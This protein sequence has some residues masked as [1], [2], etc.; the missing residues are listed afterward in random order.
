[1]IEKIDIEALI[2]LAAK[3]LA[4]Q[5]DYILKN[6]IQLTADQQIDAHL[7]GVKNPAKIRVMEFATMPNPTSPELSIAANEIGLVTSNAKGV[8]FRYGIA[9]AAGF[10]I[11]RRLLVH[12]MT[13]TAQYERLGSIEEFLTQYIDECMTVGYPHG[14]MEGEAQMMEYK[15]CD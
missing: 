5:E 9:I 4:E 3:W 14:E 15:I 10:T 13:H 6:G 8:C 12:E 1:M 2:P 7:A 11:S